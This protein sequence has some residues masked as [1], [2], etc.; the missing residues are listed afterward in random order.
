MTPR[1]R[2]LAAISHEKVDKVPCD[3][4]GTPEVVAMLKRYFGISEELELWTKLGVDKIVDLTPYHTLGVPLPPFFY[5]GPCR[6]QNQDIWG[7]D[8]IPQGYSGGVY[9]EIG[10]NP[11]ASMDTIEEVESNYTFPKVDWFDFSHFSSLFREQVVRCRSYAIKCGYI[12]PLYVYLNLRGVEKGLMDFVVNR[13]YA[14]YVLGK[15]CDF[16][17]CFHE[18]LFEVG[19]GFIDIA[20]VTDDFGMQTGLLVGPRVFE[21]F[22]QPRYQCFVRLLK[23]FGIRVFHHDDGAIR[24]LIPRLVELGIEVLNPIQWKLPDMD[25]RALKEDFGSALCFHGGVDNQETLPFGNTTDVEH[26]VVYL[27][28]ALAS[29]GTGYILAPCHNIQPI[30][31][32]ENIVS[33]YRAANYWGV[34]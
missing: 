9:W 25:P 19:R 12:S 3:F 18:R 14:H 17:Y 29:D 22:F 13:E 24:P 10:F 27:L 5:R 4:W 20:E 26:E 15:I 21:E 30:T 33:M 2:V 7:V 32:L 34:L 1:E 16:L 23:D 31:P 8:Y 6:K 11:L 28:E